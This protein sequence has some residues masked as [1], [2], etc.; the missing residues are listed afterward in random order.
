[1][2]FKNGSSALITIL[3]M[4]VVISIAAFGF[5]I[6]VDKMDQHVN[7]TDT[8]NLTGI[9]YTSDIYNATN[10]TAHG[11]SNIMP[12]FIWIVIIFFMVVFLTILALALKQH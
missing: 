6:L 3:L 11:L 9:T 4:V 12:N 8:T 1:V 7:A 5:I 10:E 2:D